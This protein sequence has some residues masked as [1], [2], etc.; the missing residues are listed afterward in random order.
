MVP[1]RLAKYDPTIGPEEKCHGT[2]SPEEYVD[3]MSAVC[4]LCSV[5]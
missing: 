5:I 2:M 4:A 3:T 1:V